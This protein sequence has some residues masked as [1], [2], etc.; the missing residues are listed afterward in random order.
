MNIGEISKPSADRSQISKKLKV[1][2]PSL[3]GETDEVSDLVEL[4]KEYQERFKEEQSKKDKNIA[5]KEGDSIDSDLLGSPHP[6]I[7]LTV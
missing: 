5:A 1:T 3:I 4:S 2:E 7:D 6:K